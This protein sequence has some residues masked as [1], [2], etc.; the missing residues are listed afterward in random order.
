MWLVHLQEMYRAK[1]C[2]FAMRLPGNHASQACRCRLNLCCHRRWSGIKTPGVGEPK[3]TFSAC[4]DSSSDLSSVMRFS[5]CDDS[6]SACFTMA[7][8]SWSTFATSSDGS[9]FGVGI[10]AGSTVGDVKP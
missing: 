4:T 10:A 6:S 1:E 2:F 9:N 8:N 7:L 5:L 3:R